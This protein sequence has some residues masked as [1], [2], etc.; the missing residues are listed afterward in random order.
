MS[1][2]DDFVEIRVACFYSF[3][4]IGESH[5]V[6]LDLEVQA[7]ATDLTGG[8]TTQCSLRYFW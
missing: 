2:T 1:G 4:R 6:K 3:W 8:F 5:A 7:A